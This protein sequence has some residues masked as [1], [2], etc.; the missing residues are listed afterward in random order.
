MREIAS[1]KDAVDEL[2]EKNRNVVSQVDQSVAKI[3]ILQEECEE[4]EG[5]LAEKEALLEES[6]KESLLQKQKREFA[7][8]SLGECFV[9]SCMG[10]V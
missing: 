6:I 3:R 5:K 4:K 8:A 10:V 2:T 9:I 1:L 7:V